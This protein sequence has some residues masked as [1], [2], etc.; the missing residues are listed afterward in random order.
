MQD[1]KLIK[2]ISDLPAKARQRFKVYVNSPYFNQHEKT[3]VL[4]DYI[5]KYLGTNKKKLA[6][7]VVFKKLF[8]GETYSEQLLFNTMSSLKK[9]LHGF[10]AQQRYEEQD[11][12]EDLF[13]LESTYYNNQFD[14]LKNRAKQLDR[15]MNKHPY[16]DAQHYYTQF[17]YLNVMAYYKNQHEDRNKAN[18][19][20]QLTD[21]L[22]RYF[23]LEKLRHSCQLTAHEI[24]SNS[25][26]DY[27]FLDELITYYLKEKDRF[28]EDTSI[29]LYYTILMS[30][31]DDDNPAY[32]QDLK[33]LLQEQVHRFSP[34]EQ[35]DLYSYANNYCVRQI[36]KGAQNFQ[37]ELFELYQAG[38]SNE[39]IFT[40]GLLN[41]W[42]YKNITVLGCILGEFEWTE[43][44][45]ENYKERL[46][47]K[48]RE[49]S[50]NYNMAHLN[51]SKQRYNEALDHLL[52]VRF[53]DVTYHLNYNNLL[54]AT[55]YAL[56][57]TE[58]LMSLIDTFRIYV[59]RNRKMTNNRKKHYTNFLRFAKKITIAKQQPRSYGGPSKEEKFAQLYLQ[60]KQS[61]NIVNR[62]WLE[63]TCRS[64]AGETLEQLLAEENADSS[65]E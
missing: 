15:K 18:L 21:K 20:Q 33:L 3:I 9:L 32:Y 27:S 58:A 31:R 36:N 41:E 56:G 57:D 61:T 34:H 55:Y 46:P 54:L 24:L 52:L 25:Q 48:P 47:E 16:Q 37:K 7:E 22:D 64:E 44:F 65:A 1:S 50:Y 5:Y 38:L 63:N 42:N 43:Y 35:R 60:I 29:H 8:P 6:R 13:L 4:L 12:V 19:L 30:L 10:L 2:N 28:E 53:S 26:F 45:L 17:K 11:F 51:Y 40:N 14:L 49:N 59:I 62:Y 23:M 39:L